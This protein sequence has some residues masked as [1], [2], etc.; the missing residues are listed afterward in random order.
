MDDDKLMDIYHSIATSKSFQTCLKDLL[1][2]I[3]PLFH[4]FNFKLRHVIQQR[5]YVNTVLYYT[6]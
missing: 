5:Y 1:S 2:I 4:D 6:I 3:L